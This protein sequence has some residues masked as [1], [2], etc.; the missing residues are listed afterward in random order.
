MLGLDVMYKND[1]SNF[2]LLQIAA[3]QQRIL[4][5]RNIAFQ[6]KSGIQSFIIQSEDPGQQLIT[7][8]EIIPLKDIATPFTRCIAC[9]GKLLPVRKEEIIAA[10][11]EKT[12]KYY[13]AF[14][15]CKDCH[16]IYWKGSHFSRMKKYIEEGLKLHLL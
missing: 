5:T 14:W 2:D 6:K 7:L 11:P 1:Y 10:I 9:N 15:Q 13:D 16:K 3:T 8:N 4:L 12:I